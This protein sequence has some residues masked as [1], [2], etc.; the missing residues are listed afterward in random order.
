MLK[1]IEICINVKKQKTNRSYIVIFFYNLKT[2]IKKLIIIIHNDNNTICLMLDAWVKGFKGT[3][4]WGLVM[5]F[6]HT[7]DIGC[8]CFDFW[9]N[10]LAL[11]K[12]M[13]NSYLSWVFQGSEW[14]G[15]HLILRVAALQLCKRERVSLLCLVKRRAFVM[16]W[17]R[18][19]C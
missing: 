6:L 16:D 4:F 13:L 10:T 19:Q 11:I 7:M 9:G 15:K 8:N 14:K 12:L 3:W 2:S 18:S 1:E 5:Y 17:G